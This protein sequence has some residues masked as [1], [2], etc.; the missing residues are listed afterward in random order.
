M[1]VFYLEAF[2][3][4]SDKTL[5]AIF[6]FCPRIEK[7]HLSGFDKVPGQVHGSAL[8]ALAQDPALAPHLRELVLLDQH[9][10]HVKALSQARPGLWIHEG[11]TLGD[12]IADVSTKS[13]VRQPTATLT[14]F[15]FHLQNMIAAMTGGESVQSWLGGK[16]VRTVQDF[17]LY[18][19][20]GYEL[21]GE[22]MMDYM[23][24][25]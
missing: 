24:G 22:G 21:P 19:P 4:L 8:R 2:T 14:F 12:G 3:G 1:R 17:G 20:G 13:R 23:S 25:F 10:Q 15:P 6:D 18:G 16:I 11:S 5:L 9:V 7:V